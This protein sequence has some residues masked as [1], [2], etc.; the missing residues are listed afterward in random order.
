MLFPDDCNAPAG[1]SGDRT[2]W[3]VAYVLAST[4]AAGCH[5]IAVIGAFLTAGYVVAWTWRR[6]KALPPKLSP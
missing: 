6:R 1:E 2:G 4:V 5:E 3:R